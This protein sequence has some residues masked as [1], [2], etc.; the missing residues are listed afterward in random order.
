MIWIVY[1]SNKKDNIVLRLN[2]LCLVWCEVWVLVAIF[3]GK[4]YYL[5]YQVNWRRFWEWD[6]LD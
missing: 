1:N 3:K 6:Y 4:Y 2:E 5:V